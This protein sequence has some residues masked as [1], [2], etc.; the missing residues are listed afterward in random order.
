VIILRC[1]CDE[2]A[3]IMVVIIVVLM[4]IACEMFYIKCGVVWLLIYLLC[5]GMW[6]KLKQH[7]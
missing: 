7:L 6:C 2:I 1:Y 4:V 5:C 3:E